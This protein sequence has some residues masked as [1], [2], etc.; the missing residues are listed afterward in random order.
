M[1]R[2][3]TRRE[4]RRARCLPHEVSVQG[5]AV[6]AVYAR[7]VLWNT[8]FCELMRTVH[9]E[10]LEGIDTRPCTD[11]PVPV[12]PEPAVRSKDYGLSWHL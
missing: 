8:R 9:P 1:P 3:D 4:D 11:H 5:E 10:L 6:E 2:G 12:K 7:L